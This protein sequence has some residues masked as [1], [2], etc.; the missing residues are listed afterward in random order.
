MSTKPRPIVAANWKCNGTQASIKQLLAGFNGVSVTHPCD[1]IIAPTFLHIPLVQAT[2]TNP[3]ISLAAQNAIP[4]SGA[5]TGE[6]SLE[7]LKDFGIKQVILGHSERRQF[8]G[9]TSEVV[10]EKTRASIDAGFVV[11]LCCGE[12]LKEREEGRTATVVISQ[13]AAVVQRL[14]P[15][16][17]ER[18]VIAYEPV[19]AIGTGKVASPEQAQ[20]VHQIIRGWL[21]SAVSP[22]TSSGMRI[23]YGGSVTAANAVQLYRQLDIN[24]FLVGGASL[25]PEFADIIRAT[26]A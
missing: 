19:W 10:A 13:L 26:A 20:E 15:E 2:V 17:W 23:L 14:K 1:V 11:I 18:V 7:V 9:E 12:T 5:F 6:I 22:S 4:K 21:G 3:A 16:Q 24:G 25:K 8:Y